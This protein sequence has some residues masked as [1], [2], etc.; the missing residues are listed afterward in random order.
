MDKALEQLVTAAV[1]ILFHLYGQRLQALRPAQPPVPAPVL[2]PELVS[3]AV[4]QE[5]RSLLSRGAES[6]Q[7]DALQAKRSP[8]Q[9]SK[10]C[11][12][13]GLGNIIAFV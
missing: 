6:G 8:A 13:K 1:L 2:L 11:A 9:Q 5:K 12:W 3:F 7:T 4:L 10:G